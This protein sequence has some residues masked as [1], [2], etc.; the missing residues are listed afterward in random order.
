M[1]R[2]FFQAFALGLTASFSLLAL[3]PPPGCEYDKE[4]VLEL[5]GA[6]CAD[7]TSS[8]YTVIA[9]RD[10]DNL[11]IFLNGGG[12]C[13]DP[14]TCSKGYAANLTRRA[15][16]IDWNKGTGIR[17]HLDPK[18]PFA[19]YT[20]LTVPYCTGDLFMG[21]SVQ[22]YGTKEKPFIVRHHGYKNLELALDKAAL[23]FPRPDKVIMFGMS[24]GAIGAF[25]H[26][27]GFDSR[28]PG[29]AKYVISDA[30][31]PFKPPHLV[32][33]NYKSLL[34]VWNIF[35]N[36]PNNELGRPIEHFGDMLEYNK[37]AYPNVRYGLVQAYSDYIMTYFAYR[38]GSKDPF[39]AVK[40]TAIDVADHYLGPDA[41]NDRVFYVDSWAH[42]LS[43]GDLAKTKSMGVSLGD[44]LTSMVSDLPWDNHRPDLAVPTGQFVP[45][46]KP[47]QF[48][49]F[50]DLLPTSGA[51][52]QL[53]G[54][55][56]PEMFGF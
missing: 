25:H 23:H 45:K 12:C 11:M 36:F 2:F 6:I 44:W 1:K 35:T 30:G 40:T 16:I 14:V 5:P 48:V 22:N 7:G 33:T 55:A 28:F 3:A 31:T 15:P 29:S 38:V 10:S 21:D 26:L 8:Y 34:R 53:A 56:P 47:P 19:S 49:R 9:R 39:N 50:N 4:C 41:S 37:R 46:A 13:W 24:A 32:E 27:S 54:L 17:N 18:N 43:D 51:A 42:T 52:E 20:I